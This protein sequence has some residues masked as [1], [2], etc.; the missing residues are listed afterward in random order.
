[1]P[2]LISTVAGRGFSREAGQDRIEEREEA[3]REREKR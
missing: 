3:K 2:T 1:L